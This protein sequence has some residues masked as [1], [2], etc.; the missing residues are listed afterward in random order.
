MVFFAAHPSD[1]PGDVIAPLRLVLSSVHDAFGSRRR[2]ISGSIEGER[3]D[4]WRQDQGQSLRTCNGQPCRW[5]T[6]KPTSGPG[7]R[8]RARMLRDNLSRSTLDQYLRE[9][10]CSNF[11]IGNIGSREELDAE[12]KPN[13]TCQACS[14]M[15]QS[16]VGG[17]PLKIFGRDLVLTLRQLQKQSQY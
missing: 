6:P 7:H 5:S 17:H 4:S 15:Y 2:L 13:D 16:K 3:A 1:P 8:S 14:Y 12:S 9:Q 11:L 10:A